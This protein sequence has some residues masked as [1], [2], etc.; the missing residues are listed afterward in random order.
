M[1]VSSR[2]E[3]RVPEG[4]D[5]GGQGDA[6]D[7]VEV[8]ELGEDEVDGGEDHDE[9]GELDGFAVRADDVMEL[10]ER[11]AAGDH[12]HDVDADLHHQL[13]RHHDPQPELVP[14]GVLPELVVP[15]EA[16]TGHHLMHLHHLPQ[17]VQGDDP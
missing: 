2:S 4:H 10:L 16:L 17:R 15:I 9:V 8:G 11:L 5:G 6:G 14:E 3:G 1:G 7:G 12:V 13:L